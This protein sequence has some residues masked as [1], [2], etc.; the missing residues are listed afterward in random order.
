[1]SPRSRLVRWSRTLALVGAVALLAAACGAGNQSGYVSRA[2]EG[3]EPQP[4]D[5]RGLFPGAPWPYAD[6]YAPRANVVQTVAAPVPED[7]WSGDGWVFVANEV[8]NGVTV[9]DL[10]S[11]TPIEFVYSPDSPVPHHP[12]LSPDQRWVSTNT[13]FGSD[14]LVI[15]THNDFALTRLSFPDADDGEDVAGPLHGTYTSDS[16]YFLVALQRSGH[17]GVIDMEGADGPEIIEVLA[18]GS[19]PRDVYLTPDDEKAFVSIQSENYVAVVDVGTWEVREIE[20]S[21]ADYAGAGGGGGGMSEDGRLFAVANTPEQEVVVIDTDTEE[22]VH[23]VGDVPAPVNVEFLGTTDLIGVGNR[24]D[25]SVTFID[26]GTGELLATVETGGGANIPYLGPDGNIWVTHNGDGHLS[27]LDPETFEVIDEVSVGVNPHWLQFLPSG[28]RALATNWGED[29]ISVIDTI[30]RRQLATV[31]T[32]LNPNGIVVKTDVTREQARAAIADRERVAQA[33]EHVELASEMVLPEPRDD[34]ER[35]FLNS[36]VQ[37][38]DIGRIVRNNSD[39]YDEWYDI[40]LRMRGNGAVMTDEEMEEIAQYLA[41]GQH[42]EIEFGTRYDE[43]YDA[44]GDADPP[45][46]P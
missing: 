14:V 16:R 17:L 38:H 18:L 2:Q 6:T 35:T 22:V 11:L 7:G 20:R 44:S 5:D 36:C 25:N 15:D 13:R 37:C 19:R 42:Q 43:T 10:R 3:A 21:D 12:Y 32:G 24:S 45:R 40:V 39:T 27:V 46:A 33:V 1:V 28:S 31:Q 9:L 4:G 41:D 34:R 30:R 8:A 23:R 29:T 26:G